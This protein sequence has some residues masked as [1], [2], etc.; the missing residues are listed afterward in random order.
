MR[1]LTGF[2]QVLII[3]GRSDDRFRLRDAL[4]KPDGPFSDLPQPIIMSEKARDGRTIPEY[5][6]KLAAAADAAIAL[7]TAEDIGALAMPGGGTSG[8]VL[9][10]MRSLEPRARQNVWVEVGWFWGRL[11]RTRLMLLQK[12]PV[13]IP[14]DLGSVI[15]HEYIDDPCERIDEIGKFLEGIRSRRD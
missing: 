6:E 13:E 10:V 7:V 15:R 8:S 14:S 3:H 12:G 2:P 11:G 9:D 4:T 5:F 1:A